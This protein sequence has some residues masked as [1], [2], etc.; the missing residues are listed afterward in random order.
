MFKDI[1]N[2]VRSTFWKHTLLAGAIVVAGCIWGFVA[3]D[4]DMLLL[5]AVLAVLGAWRCVHL[6]KV[7]REGK[8]YILEGNV[9]SDI[10]H[11]MSNSR[12]I[13]LLLEDGDQITVPIAGKR[14][15]IP[16]HPY[17][18]YLYSSLQPDILEALPEAIRPAYTLFGYELLDK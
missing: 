1:P 17:R 11:T 7:M 18:I 3:D 6:Y 2:P 9:V 4:P 15:L 8:Y 10:K 12:N 5:T 16:G 13:T 14:G